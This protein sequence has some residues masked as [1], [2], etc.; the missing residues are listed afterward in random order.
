MNL[1]NLKKALTNKVTQQLE[2]DNEDLISS[3][4]DHLNGYLAFVDGQGGLVDEELEC[5]HALPSFVKNKEDFL[6]FE[7]AMSDMQAIGFAAGQKA[8]QSEI[9]KALGI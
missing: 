7:K 3:D 6:K 4:V 1:L 5:I 9:R 2:T 8:K